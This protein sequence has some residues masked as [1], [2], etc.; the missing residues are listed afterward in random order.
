[1]YQSCSLWEVAENLHGSDLTQLQRTEQITLWIKLTDERENDA[2]VARRIGKLASSPAASMPPLVSL[3]SRAPQ[4]R[5]PSSGAMALQRKSTLE[6]NNNSEPEGGGNHS[7]NRKPK[8][9]AETSIDNP[10]KG[11]SFGM[12]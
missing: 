1:L 7:A 5:S 10:P 12:N 8:E 9:P 2:A 11:R 3:V 6:T 4:R